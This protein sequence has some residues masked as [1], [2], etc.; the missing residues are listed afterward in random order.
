MAGGISPRLK[1]RKHAM[2]LVIYQTSDIHGYV[3]PTNY[4]EAVPLGILK[5]ASFIHKDEAN[6]DAS[7]KIDCGDLVQGSPMT[8]Y[9][10]K[11]RLSENVITKGMEA[12]GFD[13]YVLGN[14]EFNYGL[15]YLQTAYAPLKDKL[16]NANIEGLP[17]GSKPYG[18]FTYGSCRIACIG[19]TTAFIPNWEQEQNIKGL[20]F[21]DPVEAYGYYEAELKKQ[22]DFIIVCYHGGF[23]KTVDEEMVP[24]EKLTKENQASE[25]LETFDSIDILLSGHQHRSIMA[26]VNGVI[27]TQPLFYGQA[28]SKIVLDT[29]TKE[30]SM[31]LLST[32]DVKEP[33]LGKYENVFHDTQEKLQL[34]LDGQIGKFNGD[35]RILDIRDARFYGHPLLN[36]IHKVQLDASHAD[37]SV[38]SLFDNATGFS[39]Q[40][41]MRD[42]LINFPFP[43]TLRVLKIKGHALKEAIEKSATYFDLKHGDVIVNDAFLKPKKQSYNYDMFGGVTYEMDLKKPFYE[44]VTKLVLHGK[45]MDLDAEYRVVMNNYRASNTSVYPCYENAK[46]LQEINVDISQL[47]IDYIQKHPLMEID[48]DRNYKFLK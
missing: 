35:M 15:D 22:A 1:R 17:F 48:H 30:T 25:L 38:A 8:H 40:V 34:Y 26:R 18:I 3:Y 31:E 7:L 43:N 32:A 42:V 12:M 39:N 24:T 14:H 28:F 20:K 2:K 45:P 41:S 23:E 11:Q 27:C 47:I 29:Q 33:I 9:L 4:I 21:H 6:Y 44:R 36:F 5:I 46:V 13:V 16:L 19:L 10:Y 37:I